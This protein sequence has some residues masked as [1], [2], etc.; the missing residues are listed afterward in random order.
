[1]SHQIHSVTSDGR[2]PFK[3]WTPI[4]DA[5]LVHRHEGDGWTFRIIAH[6]IPPRSV[7]GCRQRYNRLCR[8]DLSTLELAELGQLWIAYVL[9][10]LPLVAPPC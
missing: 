2:D 4:E 6:E 1:M 10:L 9:S 7:K 3:H 5:T 8:R